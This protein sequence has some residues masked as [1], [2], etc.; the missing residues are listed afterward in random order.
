MGINDRVALLNLNIQGFSM[1]IIQII[2]APTE[3]ACEEDINTFYSNVN[4]ALDQAYKNYIIM[5]D[6]NAKIGQP[7]KDEHLIMK[8]NGYGERN[9]RGQRLI[10]FALEH[11]LAILNSFIKNQTKDGPGDHRTINTK[12]K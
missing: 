2:Y 1:S 6:F 7:R 9:Q 12:M 11:K 10:D 5:G 3:T 4:R 8:P